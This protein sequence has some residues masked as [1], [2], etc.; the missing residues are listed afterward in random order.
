[1]VFLFFLGILV[2]VVHQFLF[3]L[4]WQLVFTLSVKRF[5]F[6]LGLKKFNQNVFFKNSCSFLPITETHESDTI[7]DPVDPSALE[8]TAV[9]PRNFSVAMF[10]VMFVLTNI[11]TTCGPLKLALPVFHIVKVISLI[12]VRFAIV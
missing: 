3:E 8:S 2:Q 7:L 5:D 10:E 12:K 6:V 9:C 4:S 11:P 1:M